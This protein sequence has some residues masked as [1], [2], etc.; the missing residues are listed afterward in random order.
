[1][2]DSFVV[3]LVSA[4][5]EGEILGQVHVVETGEEVIVRNAEELLDAFTPRPAPGTTDGD[6]DLAGHQS[7]DKLEGAAP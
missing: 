1:V 4:R 7:G 6:R 3:R 5:G 2:L